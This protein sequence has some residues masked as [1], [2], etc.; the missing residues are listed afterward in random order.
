M[1]WNHTFCAY[2]SVF[3][4][5]IKNI[6]EYFKKLLKPDSVELECNNIVTA[7]SFKYYS[8]DIRGSN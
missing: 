8:K 4:N 2:H 1:K 3:S 5:N 7:S 6:D